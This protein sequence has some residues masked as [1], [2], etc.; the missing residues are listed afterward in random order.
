M[1]TEKAYFVGT[2]PN[3]FSTGEPAE[4]VGVVFVTS[5]NLEKRPY[6]RLRFKDGKEDFSPIDERKNYM[7]ISEEEM[8]EGK[9]PQGTI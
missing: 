9:I 3:S 5:D 2:H 6:F 7:L 8:K 1:K 4:I